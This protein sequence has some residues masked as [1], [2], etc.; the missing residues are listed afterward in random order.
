MNKLFLPIVLG[1]AREG[2]FSDQVANYLY[3]QAENFDIETELID[4]KD[5][6]NFSNT[7]GMSPK[8]SEVWKKIAT[9]ADGFIVVAPE[10]NHGYPGELK[11]LLDQ[12][13]PEYANK[14]V[15]ICGVSEGG[16]GGVR[17]VEQLLQ[18]FHALSVHA[19]RNG[20]L[21]ADVPNLFTKKGMLKDK[22]YNDHTK[23]MF[24]ELIWLAEALKVKREE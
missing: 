6:V 13:Y 5:Y 1:T 7:G 15:A 8:K 22:I 20:V 23:K 9:K 16:L 14:A 21:F 3:K 11:L 24:D 18:V 19:I 10:Y 4:V 2:R 17:V 12:A